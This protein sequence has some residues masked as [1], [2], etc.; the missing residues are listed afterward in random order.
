MLNAKFQA[1]LVNE[2]VTFVLYY[3]SWRETKDG[4]P[5]S[6]WLNVT[7]QIGKHLRKHLLTILFLT[8]KVKLTEAF[9]YIRVKT[10]EMKIK[11]NG[12]LKIQYLSLVTW[13]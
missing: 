9:Y 13:E 8:K 4:I 7:S 10:T 11:T 6:D 2:A 5:L 12:L 1:K 3:N